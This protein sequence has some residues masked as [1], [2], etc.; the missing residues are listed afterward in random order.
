MDSGETK[1]PFAEDQQVEIT[2]LP[3]KARVA[4]T[5][6]PVQAFP[7]LL[8]QRRLLKI[9]GLILLGVLCMA[10]LFHNTPGAWL[11][12]RSTIFGATPAPGQY[13]DLFYV[14]AGPAW[15][16]LTIDGKSI[17]NAPVEGQRPPLRLAPGTHQ[18]IWKAAPFPIQRCSISVPSRNSDTCVSTETTSAPDDQRAWIV[19]FKASLLTLT[20]DAR[21]ALTTVILHVLSSLQDSATVHSGEHFIDTLNSSGGPINTAR[22]ELTAT[23]NLTLDS[24]NNDSSCTGGDNLVGSCQLNGQDCYALCTQANSVPGYW[25]VAALVRT[26]W[27]YTNLEGHVV[28][29]NMDDELGGAAI[30]DHFLPL[31]ISWDGTNWHVQAGQGFLKGSSQVP[32]SCASASDEAALDNVFGS[33]SWQAFNWR[34]ITADNLADGCL[35]ILTS[36][37]NNLPSPTTSAQIVYLH[38]FGVFVAINLLA[39]QYDPEM[40]RPDAY[41]MTLAQ[42]LAGQNHL[43]IA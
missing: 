22:Q 19:I 30:L 42:K 43:V 18:F 21:R 39:Q 27:T 35:L 24:N 8:R 36:I 17:A 20:N 38:R 33:S 3:G 2:D 9:A 37:Q 10:F 7:R 5:P 14:N 6:S 15:A 11:S 34:Y 28:A 4:K 25:N 40:P 26:S 16:R 32:I 23:L 41:E 31:N 1:D 12:L 13:I 29:A